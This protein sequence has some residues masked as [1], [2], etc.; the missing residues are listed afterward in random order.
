M[1]TAHDESLAYLLLLYAVITFLY[2]EDDV[3]TSLVESVL[4]VRTFIAR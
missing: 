1:T 3:M 2:Y 4:K